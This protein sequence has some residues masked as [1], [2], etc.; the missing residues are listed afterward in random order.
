MKRIFL[1]PFILF[2]GFQALACDR[3][4]GMGFGSESYPGSF[5]NAS[6]DGPHSAEEPE[7]QKQGPSMY[8]ELEKPDESTSGDNSESTEQ[9]DSKE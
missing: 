3:H 8:D 1:T 9:D 2:F 6:M 7:W 4:M 5:L